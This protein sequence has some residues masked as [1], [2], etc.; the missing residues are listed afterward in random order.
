M[1]AVKSVVR[2]P[3]HFS[4]VHKVLLR[5]CEEY[6]VEVPKLDVDMSLCPPKCEACYSKFEIHMNRSTFHSLSNAVTTLRHEFAHYL[7]ELAD[8]PSKREEIRAKRF[9]KGFPMEGV[10]PKS[11]TTIERFLR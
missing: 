10:Q 8:L 11:Q 6:D 4:A 9:E 5:L 1:S 2:L 7:S 3:K